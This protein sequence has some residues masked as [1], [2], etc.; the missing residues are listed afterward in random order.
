M[1]KFKVGDI[2]VSERN[3]TCVQKVVKIVPD[4]VA[5]AKVVG[6]E[7][8]SCVTIWRLDGGPISE[9]PNKLAASWAYRKANKQELVDAL[10]RLALIID[11]LK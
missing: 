7:S 8:L 11:A 6:E 3:P 1:A 10:N 2:V 9:K 5:G 4:V